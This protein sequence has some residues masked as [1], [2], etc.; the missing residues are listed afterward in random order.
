MGI[1]EWLG[2]LMVI[3]AVIS[4]IPNPK[5]A[6]KGVP[7]V[8]STNVQMVNGHLVVPN[9][10]KAERPVSTKLSPVQSPALLD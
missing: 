1:Q 6:I 2:S 9:R 3:A 10:H 8:L 7:E 4:F 5:A